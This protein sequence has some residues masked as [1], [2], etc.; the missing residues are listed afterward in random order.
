[1]GIT[2]WRYFTCYWRNGLLAITETYPDNRP[3]IW[4]PS[5]IVGLVLS[6]NTCWTNN[7]G[8]FDLCG[9][10]I[11]HHKFPENFINNNTTTDALCI[12]DQIQMYYFRR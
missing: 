8:A 5:Y 6:T 12:L 1:M 10:N 2:R 7:E 3:D 4:N 9:K 11:R